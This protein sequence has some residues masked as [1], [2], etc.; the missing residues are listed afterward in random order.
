MY[1]YI[2]IYI[3]IKNVSLLKLECGWMERRNKKEKK[4][5]NTTLSSQLQRYKILKRALTCDTEIFIFG[6][7]PNTVSITLR[8]K[9]K[10]IQ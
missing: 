6:K 5:S 7:I 9:R 10:K 4:F 8:N 1:A 2:Y 3:Y